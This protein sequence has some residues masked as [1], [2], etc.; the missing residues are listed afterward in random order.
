MEWALRTNRSAFASALACALT[1]VACAGSDGAGSSDTGNDGGKGSLDGSMSGGQDGA[2]ND[3]GGPTG[4]D[5]STDAGPPGQIV[6]VDHVCSSALHLKVTLLD[7]ATVRFHYVVNGV[8]QIDRG[9]IT[10][11]TQ[12]TGAHSPLVADST[13]GLHVRTSAIDV[14]VTGAT[15]SIAITSV[16]TGETLWQ[17]AAPFAYGVTVNDDAG[18]PNAEGGAGATGVSFAKTLATGEAI[19]GLGEKTGVANRR[20]RAFTMWNSDPAWSDPTGA[21]QTTSDPI[22]QS[23][24]FF[25]SLPTSGHAIGA[26]LQNT[27]QTG[28]DVGAANPNTLAVTAA[29]GDADLFF[30]DGPAPN[31]V[32][33]SYS[34]LVGRAPLPPLWTLGYHQS[35]WTYT[36]QA[37]V[38]QIALEFRENNLPADGMWLDI[39]YMNGFRDFTWDPTNFSDPAGMIST[40]TN[41]GFKLTTI[42]DPGVKYD[43]GGTYASYN[44]GLEGNVF[45]PD[46]SGAPVQ[47]PCWP[48]AAV[49][50]DFT[51]PS[52]RSWWGNQIGSFMGV[53]V[54]GLWIDMN[55]PA[56]F[57]KSGFPL[58]S[59]MNGEGQAATFDE[60]KNVYAMLMAKATREGQLAVAPNRRPF[61]LT[62]S[63][64]AGSQRY[65]AVWTGDAQSTWDFLAMQPSMFQGMNVS[66]IPFVGS[67]V[68][69][70]TGGPTPEL[71]GRWFEVGAFS[72]FFRTHSQTGSANQE[73]WAFGPEILDLAQRML[74]VRYSLLPYW[75][76]SF[77][78]TSNTGTPLVRPLWFDY[79]SD[80]EA[81]NHEDEYF[82]GPSILVAPALAASITTR[83][84]YLPAGV[85][86]DFYTGASYTGPATVTLN[87]PLGRIPVLVKAGSI[88]P[89]QNVV[90]YVGEVP[91]VP[92]HF[93]VYPGGPGT[94][95]SLTFHEDDGETM[96]YATGAASTTQ[97]ALD[98]NATGLTLVIGARSAGY[99][100]PTPQSVDVRVH[101]VTAQ[102]TAVTLNGANVAGA[103]W[104]ISTRVLTIPI[105][106]FTAAQAIT[107]AYP[108]ATL[109][110]PRQVNVAYSVALPS[111]T[112]AGSTVYLASSA[113]AWTP[114]GM[115]LTT[116]GSSATGTL[117]VTEGTLVKYKYTRGAWTSVEGDGTST[118]AD[119]AN[120]EIVANWNASG[121]TSVSDTVASWKDECP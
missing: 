87:A 14:N 103:T 112:P 78:E 25:L 109:A 23:H 5:A 96:A 105:A 49:F 26:F 35:R 47:A 51:N 82:V 107:V 65:A 115:A 120:R 58:G 108:S 116:S 75:Y 86:Y 6:D 9:W 31:D 18:A 40:L 83:P 104:S 61:V 97:L 8:A 59:P 15:C 106:D 90:D 32:L 91:D 100:P 10:D 119:I 117:V 12:F 11:I 111:T 7:D 16:P 30:F 113:Q 69:G 92:R 66:G 89:E 19:Y 98:V 80:A 88:L 43:P 34:R 13:T 53:G 56:V 81:Q 84:V 93:D 71:Y 99:A 39:D 121:T 67:D 60:V 3:E 118:C 57:Q 54:Q 20:G 101:G 114:N 21:Y 24:P 46:V 45:I 74:A 77:V 63:G 38:E 94:S 70:F 102:P 1:C 64:F 72:P 2:G 68:G 85:F 17:E 28:F 33:A 50:P 48:G 55:E 52:V 41:N 29:A 79:P 36:P 62:R 76:E 4:A 44:G 73:P 27:F 110:P 22:Y 42:V 95:T 37:Y